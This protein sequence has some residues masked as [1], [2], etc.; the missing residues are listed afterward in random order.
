MKND[1]H[2]RIKKLLDDGYKGYV[3]ITCKSPSDDGKMQV[4]M[5]YDG[6]P[7]LAAYLMEGA[8]S[9]LEEESDEMIT[10]DISLA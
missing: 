1:V 5:S 7:V 3:L 8:Q 4:E 9:Y 2:T 6:D 10:Q